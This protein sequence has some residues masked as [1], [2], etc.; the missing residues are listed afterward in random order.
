ML[1]AFFRISRCRRRY[2]ISFCC[3]LMVATSSSGS[4]GPP[5]SFAGARLLRYFLFH[6]LRL[7]S[8]QPNS[9]ANC[10]WDL[11]LLISNSTAGRLNSSLYTLFLFL[12]DI[13]FL[14][15]SLGSRVRQIGAVSKHKS[16]TYVL[17]LKCY[18]CSE[19]SDGSLVTFHFSPTPS[20]FSPI[21]A[22]L[23]A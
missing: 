20:H 22:P 6:P 23:A 1:M 5:S 17:S 2:S 10:A 3:C 8:L 13:G 16:V 4:C 9:R 12:S 19:P 15:F 7:M 11:P 14:L 18:P 21:T